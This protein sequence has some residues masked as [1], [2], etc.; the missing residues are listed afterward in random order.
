LLQKCS[1]R[2]ENTFIFI[3]SNSRG[4]FEKRKK[5][6]FTGLKPLP[7]PDF[8]GSFPIIQKNRSYAACLGTLSAIL[9]IGNTRPWS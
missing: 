6:V 9:I 5:P 1:E 4:L 3:F 8:G 7:P 2:E